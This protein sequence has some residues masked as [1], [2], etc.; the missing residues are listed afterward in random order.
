MENTKS[1]FL[2]L[3]NPV[4]ESFTRFCHAKSYGVIE[5]EDLIAESVLRALEGF[6][7]LKEEQAF[8]AYL[9]SIANRI[10]SNKLRRQKFVELF[11][12]KQVKT[13]PSNDISAETKLDIEL[14]YRALNQIPE[15]QKEALILFE[16]SGFAI[17]EI[18]EIQNSGES[19]VKQRL[20][21][22]REKLAVLLTE[23]KLAKE[24]VATKSLVLN[25]L[26][27]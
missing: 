24:S 12:E 19:A 20:K 9:F 10:V 4:H 2:R 8:L 23:P 22:G 16:I 26:F 3:Y 15:K 18:A 5:P 27:F 25:S 11:K 7:N 17:K 14:L 13:I 21:R 1:D 6:H